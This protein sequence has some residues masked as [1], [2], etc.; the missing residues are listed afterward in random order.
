MKKLLW[1]VPVALFV[2]NC[3]GGG[4]NLVPLTVGNEWNY[5]TIQ[6]IDFVDTMYTDVIDTTTSVTEITAETTLDD[7][8]EVFEQVSTTTVDTV[9]YVD[10]SYVLDN[11]DFVLGYGDKADVVPDTLFAYPLEE[12]NTWTVNANET[13][14]VLGKE[15]VTV[16]AGTFDC[17]EIGYITDGDTAHMFVAEGTGTVKSTFGSSDSMMTMNSTTELQ[18]TNVE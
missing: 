7:S 1:L 18:S 5:Q 4:G 13:A 6:T 14:V 17:W 9:N 16:P 8:T 15:D 3:G 2:I 11:G 12:G 10:T